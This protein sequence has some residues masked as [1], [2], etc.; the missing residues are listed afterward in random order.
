MTLRTVDQVAEELRVS[1][2]TLRGKIAEFKP[3]LIAVGRQKLFDDRAFNFLIEAMR[4]PSASNPAPAPP[5]GGS[6]A[7]SRESAFERAL[8]LGTKGLPISALPKNVAQYVRRRSSAKLSTESQRQNA[9][10]TKL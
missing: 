9:D 2:R 7:R 8:E 10:S 5:I 6:R 1:V 3:P 4:C